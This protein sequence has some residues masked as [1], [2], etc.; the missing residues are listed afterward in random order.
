MRPDPVIVNDTLRRRSST[1][2]QNLSTSTE[3]PLKNVKYFKCH[4]NKEH[5]AKDCPQTGNITRAIVTEKEAVSD[6]ECWIR[7]GVL[8][9]ESGSAQAAISTTGPTYKVD[10]NVK[11]LKS[12]VLVD[13][14]SQISLVH[15][16]MLP[17]LKE[18]NSWS[19]EDCKRKTSKIVSQPL[20]AGGS[21]LGAK[22]VV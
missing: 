9:A 14:G 3:M 12:R 18:L 22:K 4:H 16:E 10:V 17:K 1:R 11:G 13:N 21:E 20:G 19:M 7:V 2:R 6:E 15:T 8:T 5:L